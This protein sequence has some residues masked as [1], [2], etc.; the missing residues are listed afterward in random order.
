[1]TLSSA[2]VSSLASTVGAPE[3]GLRLILGQMAGWFS[4]PGD[5]GL[6]TPQSHS[7]FTAYVICGIHRV[8]FKQS[9]A[10]VQHAF[11][12]LTGIFMAWWAIGGTT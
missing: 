10:W 11:F 6:T 8:R 7:T 5:F 2:F 12:A 9:E 4:F 1:M 3:A